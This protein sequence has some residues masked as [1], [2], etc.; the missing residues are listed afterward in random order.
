MKDGTVMNRQ[1]SYQAFFMIFYARF[2]ITKW[3][4]EEL[5]AYT[6]HVSKG[7]L[8]VFLM[9]EFMYVSHTYNEFFMLKHAE[10]TV[11]NLCQMS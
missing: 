6:I 5:K 8:V 11:S 4:F 10:Y 1:D 3:K 2:G 7:Q 9:I